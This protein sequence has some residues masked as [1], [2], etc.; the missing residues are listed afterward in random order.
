MFNLC[1]GFLI[2]STAFLTAGHC[3]VEAQSINGRNDRRLVRPHVRPRHLQLRCGG[4]TVHP[5]FLANQHSYE[6]PDMAVLALEAPIAGVEPIELPEQ[7]AA[8]DLSN[9]SELTTVGYGLT[10]ERGKNPGRCQAGFEP[11]RRFATETHELG[12]PMVHHRWPE[13]ERQ[14]RRRRHLLWRLR[15]P[16]SPAGNEHRGCTV[17]ARR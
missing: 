4:V 13:P 2:S 16:A 14:R 17:D 15:W 9:G 7:G 3:A 6:T 11:A 1:S 10:R 5:E 8:K 12:Q